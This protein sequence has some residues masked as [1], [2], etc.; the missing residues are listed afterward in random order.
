[1]LRVPIINRSSLVSRSNGIAVDL[2]PNA[3]RRPAL[4]AGKLMAAVLLYVSSTG[5]MLSVISSDLAEGIYLVFGLILMMGL[6]LLQKNRNISIFL[7]GAVLVI[8]ILVLA[9]L[10]FVEAGVQELLNRVY[11]ASEEAQA[12]QYDHYEIAM[13]ETRIMASVHYVTA[14]LGMLTGVF[15]AWAL[16]GNHRECALVPLLICSLGCAY[17]GVTPG[18]IWTLLYIVAV[19]LTLTCYEKEGSAGFAAKLLYGL[20]AG[21]VLAMIV[22]LFWKGTNAAVQKASEDVRDRMALQTAAYSDEQSLKIEKEEEIIQEQQEQEFQQEDVPETDDGEERDWA[23]MFSIALVI[24]MV[25]SA[26]FIPSVF[27]D[28]CEKKR[29]RNREGIDDPDPSRAIIAMFPYILRWLR[30][31]G[32]EE[33]NRLYSQCGADVPEQNGLQKDYLSMVTMWQEAFYS[34]HPMKEEQKD[35]MNSYLLRTQQLVE[36]RSNWKEKIRIRYIEAL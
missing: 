31:T 17:Y 2:Q 7:I 9:R 25:A 23:K 20:T 22:F 26:L 4:E 32:W 27:R 21:L 28:L 13:N 29:M 18:T 16:K 33:D 1:M 34:N 30:H 10:P 6:L 19:L 24:L 14:L 8:G 5:L 15:F 12:Y 36:E 3:V 35:Q 11:E